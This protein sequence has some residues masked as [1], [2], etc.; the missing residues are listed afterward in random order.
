MFG[1]LSSV[2]ATKKQIKKCV[3]KEAGIIGLIG[4][5]L[6]ILSG[7]LA[8]YILIIIMNSLLGDFVLGSDFVFKISILPIFF[9]LF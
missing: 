4:I 8:D 3:L 2:G 6:G 9:Q 7:I 5:P 1:M